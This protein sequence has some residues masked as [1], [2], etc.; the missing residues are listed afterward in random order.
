MAFRKD[1]EFLE[2]LPKWADEYI[3]VCIKTTKEVATGSGK[4]VEIRDRHL[5]TISYFTQIWLPREK[6][7][8]ITRDCWYKW[9]NGDNEQKVTLI[10]SINE[11]FK[12]LA[13][14]IVA[15]EQKGI[16]YAKNYLSMTDRVDTKNEN[17]NHDVTAEFGGAKPNE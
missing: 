9:L 6:K 14:D 7:E 11:M 5:P 16:F 1:E 3:D 8:S 4:I 17:F 12:A 2:N 13:T 15:N 10:N